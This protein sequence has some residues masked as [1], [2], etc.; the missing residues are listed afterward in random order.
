M[1]RTGAAGVGG[2][3][4]FTLRDV[5]LAVQIAICAVLVT[6]SLVA[7]RGLARSMHSNFGFVPQNVMLAGTELH[8]SGYT[9]ERMPQMQRRMLD[10]AAAIPGV[11][12][13]GYVDHLPLGLGGGDSFVY[14]DS[15]TDFR[16]DQ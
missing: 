8:M 2:L 11:T 16:P 14:T 12:A 15:T 10:A 5:L 4:R 3:R 9:D 13:V 6:S 1:I 7:V